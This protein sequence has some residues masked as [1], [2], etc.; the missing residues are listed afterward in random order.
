MGVSGRCEMRAYLH[1][2]WGLGVRSPVCSICS[3]Q[4][5][6]G[7]SVNSA[8]V[9]KRAAHPGAV[10]RRPRA[11]AHVTCERACVIDPGGCGRTRHVTHTHKGSDVQAV[12]SPRSASVQHAFRNGSA[13]VQHRFRLRSAALQA[14]PRVRVFLPRHPRLPAA[15]GF[16]DRFSIA[17]GC[18]QRAF[19]AR[20]A[21]LARE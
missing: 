8:I 16:Q 19:S 13:N 10:A 9:T 18:V 15:R 17:S 3:D 6:T 20:S 1:V 14:A 2:V 7:M 4:R 5:V 11:R 21:N 12:L